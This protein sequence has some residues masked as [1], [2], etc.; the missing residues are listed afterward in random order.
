MSTVEIKLPDSLA[1]Q[2]QEAGLLAPE[3]IE[4]LIAE[5]LRERRIERLFEIKREL[6]AAGVAPM[7]AEEIEAE[8]RAARDEDRRARFASKISFWCM[9]VG[10]QDV[11]GITV[12]LLVGFFKPT[13]YFQRLV[14]CFTGH[15]KA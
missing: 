15:H 11:R 8:I 14:G 4:Q 7:T 10:S 6:R 12:P 1:K 9:L 2:A 5:A 3:A 13:Q